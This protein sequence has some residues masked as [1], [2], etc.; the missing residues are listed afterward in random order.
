M[1]EKG[2][3][4]SRVTDLCLPAFVEFVEPNDNYRHLLADHEGV[5]H[6]C[7]PNYFA[8]NNGYNFFQGPNSLF[9][10]CLYG[11][12]VNDYNFEYGSKFWNSY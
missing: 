9:R 8:P 4:T 6:A 11:K 7:D 10:R 1:K 3:L 12:E 5:V 2:Y